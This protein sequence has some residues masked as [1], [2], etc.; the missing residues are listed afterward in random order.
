MNVFLAQRAISEETRSRFLTKSGRSRPAMMICET[1]NACNL[2]CIICAYSHQERAKESM[3]LDLFEKVLRDYDEMGGGYLS[4]T[5]TVG[6]IFLDAR[7][8]E[9][10]A[11]A[12]SIPSIKGISVTTNAVLANRIP[13]QDL[14]YILSRFHRVQV[15]IYG[16]DR[17]EYREM[18]RRDNYVEMVASVRT[19]LEICGDS[20]KV[21]FGFR[22]LKSRGIEAMQ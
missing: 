19:I 7:L 17:D 18:T 1:V 12:A 3:S 10:L 14:E 9:R 11:L 8:R 16:L 13:R 21:V 2:D 22:L 20:G 6:D 5:P 4:L 15:S